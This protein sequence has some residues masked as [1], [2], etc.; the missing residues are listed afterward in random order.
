[1]H[2]NLRLLLAALAAAAFCIGF[3]TGLGWRP[4]LALK[5]VPV[6]LALDWLR[7]EAEPA[8][9]RNWIG[10]GLVL[11]LLGD[12]LL[13]LPNDPFVAGLVAFLLAH[14]AY[15][16]GYL[17]RSRVPA[18]PWL[19]VAA[20]AVAGFLYL[21]DTRGDLGPLRVPV[22]VYAA[23]IGAMLWRAGSLARLDR[24]GRWALAGAALFVASDMVL[25]WNRFIAPD[26][27]LRYVNI[28][29]YWAGQWG[30]AASV[31]RLRGSVAGRL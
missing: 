29:L 12:A 18:W 11:S 30:I 8:R 10:V 3:A 25:A 4:M 13:A 26:P 16:V 23:V 15:V 1:M 6:L 22:F 28:L 24:A 27:T 5:L 21:L 7:A 14:L 2:P 9:Y 17:T 19:L 20:L 31:V